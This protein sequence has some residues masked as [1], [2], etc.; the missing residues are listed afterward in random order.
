MTIS[1]TLPV[2]CTVQFEHSHMPPSLQHPHCGAM[3]T[4]TALCSPPLYESPSPVAGAHGHS[5]PN[6][7]HQQQL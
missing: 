6:F 5:F 1:L 4:A 3:Q 7:S 2:A